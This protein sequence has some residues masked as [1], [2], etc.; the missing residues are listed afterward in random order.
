MP[1]RSNAF[2]AFCF[3][4]FA[5]LLQMSFVRWLRLPYLFWRVM[6]CIPNPEFR[7]LQN[8][9]WKLPQLP[10]CVLVNSGFLEVMFSSTQLKRT[11]IYYL[12]VYVNHAELGHFSLL[13]S[14]ASFRLWK[15]TCHGRGKARQSKGKTAEGKPKF[16]LKEEKFLWKQTF[17][18]RAFGKNPWSAAVCLHRSWS[19]SRAGWT[20][21]G[22]AWVVGSRWSF[23]DDWTLLFRCVVVLFHLG[24]GCLFDCLIPNSG[25]R[26]FL[27]I[28]C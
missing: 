27:L 14:N 15:Q 19:G 4:L 10:H 9:H 11:H 13:V 5:S 1:Q 7:V 20:N 8:K 17:A 26:T 25:F 21:R 16:P 18:L 12:N 2:Y 22:A 28:L 24:F 23:D 3:L 6:H